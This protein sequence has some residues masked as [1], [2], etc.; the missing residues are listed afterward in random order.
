MRVVGCLTVYRY[1]SLWACSFVFLHRHTQKAPLQRL[2]MLQTIRAQPWIP[3]YRAY[4]SSCPEHRNCIAQQ[5]S[6]HR[7]VLWQRLYS[8]GNVVFS[9]W[10]SSQKEESEALALKLANLFI[11]VLAS[12][13][14]YVNNCAFQCVQYTC[15]AFRPPQNVD[16]FVTPCV[17]AELSY[18]TVIKPSYWICTAH[19]ILCG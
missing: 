8:V 12:G 9:F 11:L 2:P 7:D 16:T 10:A 18:I 17:G 19:P 13:G 3:L 1:N 4:L 14:R 6:M 5:A 15:V